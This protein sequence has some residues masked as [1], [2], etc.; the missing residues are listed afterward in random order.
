[1]SVS[2]IETFVLSWEIFLGSSSKFLGDTMGNS[3]CKMDYSKGEVNV[4]KITQIRL[5]KNE[6]ECSYGKFLLFG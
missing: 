5:E 1:M 4:V 2:F 3:Y 6:E